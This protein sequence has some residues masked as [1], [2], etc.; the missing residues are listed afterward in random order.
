MTDAKIRIKRD[1]DIAK[2]KDKEWLYTNGLGSYSSSSIIG[3]NTRKYHGL[4]VASFNPPTERRILVSKVEE[5]ILM[6][7]QE[8][9]LSTNQYPGTFYPQGYLFQRSFERKPFPKFAYKVEDLEIEKTVFMVQG[10]NTTIVQYQNASKGSLRIRLNPLYSDRDYHGLFFENGQYDFYLDQTDQTHRIY[11]HYGVPP[12]YFKYSKGD[13]REDRHWFKSMEYWI[14]EYRG[15]DFAEDIYSTG[16]VDVELSAGESVYL[17]F[18]QE[19]NMLEADPAVLKAEEEDYQ[20]KLIPETVKDEFV[21]DLIIAGDQFIVRRKSTESSSIIAG[22]H[23]FT[24]WARDTMISMLGLCIATGRKDTAKS[25]MQT[26][27]NY[28]DQGMLP[29]RFPDYE[30]EEPEYNTVDGTLWL[31][32][33]V[34]EYYLKFDDKVFLKTVFLKLEEIIEYHLQGT[35]YDIHMCE[36]GLLYAGNEKTQLTWMDAR[37]GDYV[38]TSRHGCPVEVNALWYNALMIFC[39]ISRE[40]DNDPKDTAELSEKVKES[41]HKKFM[42]ADGYLHDV[43]LDD[44]RVDGS[45][46][47]NQIYA[48]SLPFSL[49]NKKEEAAVLDVVEKHLLTNLGLRTLDQKNIDFRPTYGGNP[50]SRDTAYHQGTVWPFVLGEYYLAYL[51]AHDNSQQAKQFVKDHMLGLRDHF[52]EDSCI[53]GVSEIFDGLKPGHGRGCTHQAWSVAQLLRVIFKAGLFDTHHD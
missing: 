52:Y 21:K 38:V 26:F 14:E 20:R 46:R 28:L 36:D 53:L 22:Y 48:L 4:L 8:Y 34:Y 12:L 10:S 45:I 43:Y 41:F 31:F 27:L 15:M 6:K 5:A 40:L 39:Y 11:S 9:S 18:T 32:I 33:A 35:R 16:H 1:T 42:N 30:G 3:M 37:V 44:N 29:N 19:E 49:L 50:W 2:L 51:K 23:W 13:F 47:P 17:T 25:I 24:D 7:G